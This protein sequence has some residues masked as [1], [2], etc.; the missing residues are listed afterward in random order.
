VVDLKLLCEFLGEA[1]NW[2]V[3]T[4]ATCARIDERQQSNRFLCLP[5]AFS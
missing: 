5:A 2:P 1:E 3:A 4:P